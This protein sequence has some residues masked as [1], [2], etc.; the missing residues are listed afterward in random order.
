[1][2]F[3]SSRRAVL[4]AGLV[5]AAMPRAFAQG[6]IPI[7]VIG[8]GNIGGTLGGLLVKAGHPVMF[9]SRN[10]DELKPLVEK[11][12]PL[13]KA[14]TVAEAAKF[15]QA[16]LTAVPYGALP[17]IGQDNAAAFKG[18]L[19]LD[20]SNAVPNRDP[21]ALVDEVKANGPGITSQKYL[22][23]AHVVRAFNAI[24]Y[25]IFASEAG[26]PDPKLPVPYAGDDP[27]AMKLAA[28]LI[29]DMGF[30]PVDAGGLKNA[31]KFYLGAPASG[32][33]KDAAEMKA[34]LSAAP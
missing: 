3:S 21:Q 34:K 23:S 2:I 12:G 16:F 1:M 28:E 18:K 33:A 17:G 8:S 10:P 7:G 11:L 5:L 27:A 19:V 6:K 31:G 29:R 15:G 25:K 4:G 9:S 22:A 24:N 26:R 14:G 30:E 20:A 13:A 32:A